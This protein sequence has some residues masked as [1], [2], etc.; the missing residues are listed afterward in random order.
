MLK[1]PDDIPAFGDDEELKDYL[2]SRVQGQGTSSKN[3]L[4]IIVP[5][6]FGRVYAQLCV[7][8]ILHR[9]AKRIDALK[10][11]QEEQKHLVKL[12]IPRRSVSRLK[13]ELAFLK[14]DKLTV[15]PELENVAAHAI[16]GL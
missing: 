12:K 4:A 10:D 16:E 14:V 8:T 1:P 3:P 2:P 11:S 6:Q 5:R 9:E 13:R 7:S 15:F